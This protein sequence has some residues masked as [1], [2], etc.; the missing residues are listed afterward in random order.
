M[1]RVRR[2][3]GSWLLGYG[4]GQRKALHEVGLRYK[5]SCPIKSVDAKLVMM[6]MI[7]NE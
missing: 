1:P 3:S 4:S 6:I 2:T 7:V 5:A